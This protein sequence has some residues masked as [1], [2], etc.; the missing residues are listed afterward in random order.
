M[1]PGRH[2]LDQIRLHWRDWFRKRKDDYEYMYS[3]LQDLWKVWETKEDAAIAEEMV[4][5]IQE[6][7]TRLIAI[8]ESECPIAF[9]KPSWE[10]AQF[11]NA[12]HPDF[13]PHIAPDG[14]RSLCNYTTNRGGK[15]TGMVIFLLLWLIPNDPAWLMFQ[16]HEDVEGKKHGCD[17]GPYRVL[18]RPEW[19]RWR[20]TGKMYYD[21]TQA[22]KGPCEI[23]CGIE[24]DSSWNDKVG[25]EILKWLPRS[26]IKR[27]DDGGLGVFKQE[28]RIELRNGTTISGKTYNSDIQSWAG[29]A[30]WAI[31]MDEGFPRDKYDEAT[32]RVQDGGYWLHA[33]TAAEARNTGQ[34]AKVAHDCYKGHLKLIGKAKFFTGFRMDMI[35]EW[36]MP[37]GKK[38]DDLERL[39]KQGE[40][41][42]VRMG[43]IPFFE[44]SPLVFN[45]FDRS[46]NL[47][48]IDGSDVLLAIKGEN[49]ERWKTDLGHT[50]AQRLQGLLYR[51][52]IVRGGDEGMAS[53]SACQWCAILQTGE[54]VYFKGWEQAGLSVSQRCE[55]IVDL[56][57]NKREL[58]KWDADEHRRTYKE[59]HVGMKIR[60]TFFDS[61]IF[62]RNQEDPMD[63]WATTYWRA[64]LKIERASTIGPAARCDTLNDMLRAD[65]TRQHLIRA[66]DS[67]PRA[68]ITRDNVKLIERM[69]NFLFE[70]FTTGSRAGEF[71][72]QT[73]RKDDHTTDCAGYIAASKLRWANTE[74]QIIPPPRPVNKLTGYQPL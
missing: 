21:A 57:G 16:E 62:K 32:L 30:V 35:P 58:V 46:R 73:E 26:E 42:R 19:E 53:P 7:Q 33:Y 31:A 56:S 68:Y 44:S 11:L 15:T 70:Q 28:R 63:S 52:N 71:T 39:A 3:V 74:E 50:Q 14:Y 29:K 65:P 48:E 23:W 51:A 64:G 61:K 13:E 22:P 1:S 47:L 60:R 24:D 69:E 34:R 49:V 59:K 18:P 25:K 2:G 67:G 4:E 8:A 12:W 55:A 37:A 17:R 41:G 36:I 9:F 20:R 38:A 5:W 6:A 43:I 72:G 54:Y 40:M 10:Q 27:R 66:S 45:N